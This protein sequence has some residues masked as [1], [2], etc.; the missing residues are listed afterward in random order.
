M[1]MGLASVTVTALYT[2][3]SLEKAVSDLYE[4][5]RHCFSLA[6]KSE[7]ADDVLRLAGITLALSTTWLGK[8]GIDT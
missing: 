2:D 3:H 8:R 5:A 6:L 1:A 7:N 4:V